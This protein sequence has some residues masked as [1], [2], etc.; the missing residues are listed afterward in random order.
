M[1]ILSRLAAC[2]V[3][4]ALLL[5]GA[6]ASAEDVR[7]LGYEG[8]KLYIISPADGATVKSPFTVR[9]GLSGMGVAP[10]GVAKER[11]GHHHVL[12]DTDPN[13]LD[14]S[15]PL[16][17]GEKVRHFGGGQTEAQLELP[18]GKHTLQ[19]VLGDENHIPFNPPLMSEKISI[20]VRK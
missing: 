1:K 20:T 2:L 5:A 19:L 14:L 9:F 6:T 12:I 16:P 8:T 3:A 10:A 11:T 18:P 15:Q 17:A 4:P 7:K 13:T